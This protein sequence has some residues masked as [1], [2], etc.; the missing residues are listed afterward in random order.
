[1]PPGILLLHSFKSG[2]P[3][4]GPVLAYRFNKCLL[5]VCTRFRRHKCLLGVYTR[6]RKTNDYKCLKTDRAQFFI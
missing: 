4:A 2:K 3:S 5:E 1:M 6:L